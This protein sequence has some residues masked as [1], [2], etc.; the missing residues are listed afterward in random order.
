MNQCLLCFIFVARKSPSLPVTCARKAVY[1][2]YNCHKRYETD[3]FFSLWIAFH[4][5]MPYMTYWGP[6]KEWFSFESSVVKF[7]ST[8]NRVF[9]QKCENQKIFTF[10]RMRRQESRLLQI[11]GFTSGIGGINH[12]WCLENT[13]KACKSRAVKRVIYRLFFSQHPKLISQAQ[14]T[15]SSTDRGKHRKKGLKLP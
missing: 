12:A 10:P 7:S 13:R 6:V 3:R 1:R 5:N 4:G 14:L 15:S 2:L 11:Y 8:E 9:K